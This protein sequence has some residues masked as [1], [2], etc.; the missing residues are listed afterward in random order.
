[1]VEVRKYFYQV[2]Q[3]LLIGDLEGSGGR[4]G[5][6]GEYKRKGEYSREGGKEG[7]GW[8]MYERGKC[9]GSKKK[10]RRKKG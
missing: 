10:K 9:E 5:G 7:K 4:V 1:M 2:F 8:G 6:W 3:L